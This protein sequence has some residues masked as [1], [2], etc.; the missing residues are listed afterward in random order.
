MRGVKSMHIRYRALDRGDLFGVQS[1][2][3]VAELLRRHPHGVQANF[4]E[5]FGQRQH[6]SVAVASYR[7]DDALRRRRDMRGFT[8]RRS[9]Q[10]V[11]SL[12]CSE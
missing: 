2:L 1:A 5:L 9:L 7:V 12:R 3:G 8:L 6:G 10:G 11:V 4:V